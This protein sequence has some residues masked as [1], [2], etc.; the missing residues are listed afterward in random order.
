MT[1]LAT[2][3]P[4]PIY[5]WM[6]RYFGWNK[7]FIVN[8]VTVRRENCQG[9]IADSRDLTGQG[10]QPCGNL[11]EAGQNLCESCRLEMGL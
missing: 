3:E 8:V 4:L 11:A 7:P 2:N 9:M 1:D 10:A 5:D 6:C